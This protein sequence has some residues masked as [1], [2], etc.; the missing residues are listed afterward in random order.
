MK[1]VPTLPDAFFWSKEGT[2]EVLHQP[3]CTLE[4]IKRL[5]KEKKKF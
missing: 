4:N 5:T 3:I 1:S 2:Y